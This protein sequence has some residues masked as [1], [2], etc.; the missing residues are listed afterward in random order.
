MAPPPTEAGAPSAGGEFDHKEQRDAAA[1]EAMVRARITAAFA[2]TELRL[3]NDSLHHVGHAGVK[4][5]SNRHS[6]L[7]VEIVSSAFQGVTQPARHRMV[8]ALFAAELA[9]DRSL[10]ALSMSTRTPA[11]AA[12]FRE[13]AER[14]DAQ[15]QAAARERNERQQRNVRDH[16][17]RQHELDVLAAAAD[18]AAAEGTPG[19]APSAEKGPA[20]AA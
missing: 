18:A 9:D 12:R 1:F 19:A 16:R 11:E 5:Y 4:D 20:P 8:Y 17:S 10:H 15:L 3:Y 13:R 7:R 2:P 14:E 6:H